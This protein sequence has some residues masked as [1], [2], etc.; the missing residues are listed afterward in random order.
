MCKSGRVGG[1]YVT[2]RPPDI[3]ELFGASPTGR[4][5]VSAAKINVIIF[6][7]PVNKGYL[8]VTKYKSRIDK[9]VLH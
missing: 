1:I 3:A 4:L 2:P 5:H 7:L 6:R 8:D 9:A